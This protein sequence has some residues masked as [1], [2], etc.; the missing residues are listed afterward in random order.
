MMLMRVGIY[1]LHDFSNANTIKR[2]FDM[3]VYGKMRI[4]ARPPDDHMNKYFIFPIKSVKYVW[5][6]VYALVC[7]LIL[8]IHKHNLFYW[9]SIHTRMHLFI[10]SICILLH[11]LAWSEYEISWE[12]FCMVTKLFSYQHDVLNK[13]TYAYLHLNQMFHC[14]RPKYIQFKYISSLT[15]W[16]KRIK[17]KKRI[18][19]SEMHRIK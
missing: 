6:Y 8:N 14:C 7:R 11:R 18:C 5:V 15:Y 1:I 19:V 16:K 4:N 9:I 10:V 17:E 13:W 2:S 12:S 3:R